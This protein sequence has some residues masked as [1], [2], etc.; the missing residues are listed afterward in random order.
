MSAPASRSQASMIQRLGP[1]F[2]N[3]HL[4][5]GTQTAPDHRLGDFPRYKWEVLRPH[6][7]ERLEGWT[8]LDLGCNAG[9]YSFELA[10]R[11]AKVTAI[12]LDEHYLQQARWAARE[13]GLQDAID[14]RQM[15]VYDLARMEDRFDLVLFMGLF[16]HLRYPMLGLDLVASRTRRLLIFQTL[17]MAGLDVEPE[18]LDQPLEARES[19]TRPG[20]P[21][22]AFIEHSFAGDPTNWWVPNHSCVLAMLRSCGFTVTAHLGHEIYLCESGGGGP[23]GR[24]AWHRKAELLAATG[25]PWQAPADEA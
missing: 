12:D 22:M 1:W 18:I 17:T 23:T 11:G 13:Y 10:R 15:Q 16:Y 2:H 9:F 24:M 8:A 6:L 21:R 25:R 20:W 7:P 5:D 19:L 14:F 3:L 4:P